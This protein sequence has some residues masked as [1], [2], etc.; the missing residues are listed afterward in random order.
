MTRKLGRRAILTGGAAVMASAA[1]AAASPRLDS[2][3]DIFERTVPDDL[4]PFW[5]PDNR[6]PQPARQ[7]T[8]PEGSVRSN[9]S[10]FTQQRWQDHFKNTKNGVILCD[11]PSRAVHFWSE[12]E[13]IYQVF[14]SSVP[15]SEDL[16]KTGYTEIVRKVEGPTW[17]PTPSMRERFPDWPA[18]VQANDPLNPLGSHALYL[19]W[20]YYRIHGTHDTRKIGRRSSDGCIG[21]YNHQ[22]AQLYGLAKVGTQVRII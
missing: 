14:P 2:L 12:D 15:I 6:R 13:S 22:I 10:G 9:V 7:D 11:T 19:S 17:R 18:V 4:N 21:L 5:Q 3:I 20:Q 1:S 16:L 8:A